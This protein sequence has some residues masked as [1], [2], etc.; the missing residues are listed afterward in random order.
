MSWQIYL[1]ISIILISCNG[2]FHRSLMKDDRSDSRAQTI[3]FL[4]IGGIIAIFIALI[5]GKLQFSFP[6]F[7]I[8]NFVLLIFLSTPAYLLTYR[9]YQLIG[10]S[11]VVLF[12]TT[13]RLWNVVGA[14]LFLHESITSIKVLGAIIIL[15]GIGIVL[16]DK[17]KFIFNKGVIFALLAAFLFGM[18]DINGFYILKTVSAANFLIYAELL[19]VIVLLLLQP[20][21]VKK[22]TY[23]FQKDKA[24]KIIALT[25]FD[26]FGSLAL[27]LAYQTGGKASVIGPLSATRVLITILLA[28]FLLKERNNIANK[29]IG[30]VVTLVGVMLLL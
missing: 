11:E 24:I 3:V 7:L 8:W 5:Q 18:S 25:I 17:K 19:P 10:A 29:I 16:Y 22:L 12:L 2:L 13:G 4:G 27:F 1:I 23:Y 30:A 14:T 26:V 9:S 20:K 28:M 6:I 21:I 15:V